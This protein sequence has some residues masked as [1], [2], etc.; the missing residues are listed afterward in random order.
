MLCRSSNE[1]PVVSVELSEKPSW[2]NAEVAQNG[3][4]T[5]RVALLTMSTRDVRL[6]QLMFVL[7]SDTIIKDFPLHES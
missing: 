2:Q 5:K 7:F 1:T 3:I 6:L 4:G